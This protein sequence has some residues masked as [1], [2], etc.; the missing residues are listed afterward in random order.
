MASAKEQRYVAR[1]P[2][3]YG[4]KAT[5]SLDAGQVFTLEGARNDEKLLRLGYCRPMERGE[6]TY[7]CGECGA[8]FIGVAERTAHG[9]KRHRGYE[10]TP[11]QE[12][13]E[14]EREERRLLATSPLYVGNAAAAQA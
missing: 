2:M 6:T 8:E 9:Q 3:D 7:A 13:E 5:V 1:W 14:A 10:L 12:D 4:V 11:A